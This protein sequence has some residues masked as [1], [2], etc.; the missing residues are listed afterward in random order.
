MTAFLV[1]GAAVPGWCERPEVFRSVVR[2]LKSIWFRLFEKYSGGHGPM[3]YMMGIQRTSVCDCHGTFLVCVNCSDMS[4]GR[5]E[6]YRSDLRRFF[7]F[8]FYREEGSPCRVWFQLYDNTWCP[9]EF[10]IGQWGVSPDCFSLL[11]DW[12]ICTGFRTA[13]YEYGDDDDE[14]DDE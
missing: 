4:W 14:E 7:Y 13:F 10:R 8:F 9:E 2:G 1:F 12:R 5:L 11:D 6:K 3:R